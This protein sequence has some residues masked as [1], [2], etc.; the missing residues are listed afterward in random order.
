MLG[1][2]PQDIPL[3]SSKPL[4][5]FSEES[6]NT[7]VKFTQM[8]SDVHLLFHESLSNV[9]LRILFMYSNGSLGFLQHFPVFFFQDL[10]L[11]LSISSSL[12]FHSLMISVTAFICFSD[13]LLMFY[14]K[15]FF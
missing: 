10:S 7:T 1:D 15:S 12:M 13:V 14:L 6:P 3:D 8:S 9:L 2:V 5:R 4:L 11:I